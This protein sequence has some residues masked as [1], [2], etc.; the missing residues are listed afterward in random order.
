MVRFWITPP[1]ASLRRHAQ[2]FFDNTPECFRPI[3]PITANVFSLLEIRRSATCR[4]HKARICLTLEL[5]RGRLDTAWVRPVRRASP[6]QGRMR[7]SERSLWLIRPFRRR[8]ARKVCPGKT[9][10]ASDGHGVQ[11]V[12]CE[13][14]QAAMSNGK[15]VEPVKGFQRLW[16]KATNS[17]SLKGPLRLA[18]ITWGE[19]PIASPFVSASIPST[20]DLKDSRV[21][22]RAKFVALKH[23]ER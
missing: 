18:F 21:D 2:P 16:K 22:P 9:G 1:T 10:L 19:F 3:C 23:G 20:W 12:R 15:I 6:W 11:R 13:L 4:S 5:G 17:V 14:E 7:R 8:R